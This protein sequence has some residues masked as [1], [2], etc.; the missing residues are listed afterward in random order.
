MLHVP[1]SGCTTVA[2]AAAISAAAEFGVTLAAPGTANVKTDWTEIVSA[3][4]ADAMGITI[5]ISSPPAGSTNTRRL[6]DIGIGAA[7][8]EQ[9]FIANLLAGNCG[10]WISAAAQPIMYHFPVFI[11]AGT[12]LSARHQSSSTTV[13]ATIGI[14]LNR[15]PRGLCGWVG[16]RVLTFGANTANSSATSVPQANGSYGTTTVIGSATPVTLR[17]LQLGQDLLTDTTGNTKRGLVRIGFQ[18]PVTWLIS[19]LPFKES[20]TTENPFMNETNF[21]LSQL[22][23]VIP[24]GRQIILATTVNTA[25]ENRGWAVYGVA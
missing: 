9:V 2:P 22:R 7:G 14:W 10:E 24:A 8:Q 6:V 23:P 25:A 12:R 3:T 21:L 5:A 18:T 4:T 19:D 16:T 1:A 13:T 11:P 17:Y 20:T 15:S